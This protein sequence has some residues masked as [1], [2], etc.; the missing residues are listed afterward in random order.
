MS[1][2]KLLSVLKSYGI[3]NNAFYWMQ[4]FITDRYQRVCI[5][6]ALTSF[7]PVTSGVRQGNV[8]GPPLFSI[9][10][11]NLTVSCYPKHA[12]SS[13]FFFGSGYFAVDGNLPSETILP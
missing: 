13:M 12:V 1:H 6:N 11:N 7:L 8:L 2:T 10:I 5:K 9:V 4:A 3:A